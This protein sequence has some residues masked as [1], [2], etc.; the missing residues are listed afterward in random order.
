MNGDERSASLPGCREASRVLLRAVNNSKGIDFSIIVNHGYI[1]IGYYN[2]EPN[3]RRDIRFT[4][5]LCL[6]VSGLFQKDG[7]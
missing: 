2:L 7:S 4:T 1:L 6:K 3:M 5:D